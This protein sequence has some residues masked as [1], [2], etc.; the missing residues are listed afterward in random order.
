MTE[1]PKYSLLGGGVS[2]KDCPIGVHMLPY[3]RTL[4]DKKLCLAFFI[5]PT[6]DI[7]VMFGHG[8]VR[9]FL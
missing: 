9:E 8:S 5:V 2:N 6:S 7:Q 3:H 4:G 1:H